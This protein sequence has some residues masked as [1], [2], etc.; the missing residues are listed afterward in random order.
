MLRWLLLAAA[1]GCLV[2]VGAKAEQASQPASSAAGGID[3]G[4][5]HACALLPS[6]SVRCWGYG[7]DGSL[8]YG[9]RAA[10][11][12]DET[13]GAAGPVDLGAGR[14]STALS[15][16]DVHTCALLDDGAD[17]DAPEKLS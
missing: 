13:P 11:G 1:V 17:N 9:N 3:V 16:G 15:A 6:A 5:F 8:G 10:I 4:R 12:D 14:T 7:M 2:P